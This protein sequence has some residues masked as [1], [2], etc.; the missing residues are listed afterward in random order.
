MPIFIIDLEETLVHRF[1][2][3][4][5]NDEDAYT[6]AV[7]NRGAVTFSECTELN[8]EVSEW[9]DGGRPPVPVIDFGSGGEL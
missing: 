7:E 9:R 8:V 3:E 1:A 6:V 5:E 4:A 2:V